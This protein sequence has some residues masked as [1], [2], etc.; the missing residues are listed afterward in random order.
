MKTTRVVIVTGLSGSGKTTTINALEDLGFFCVDN[1]P[2][3]LMD[4]FLS[5][6]E[7]DLDIRKVALGIDARDRRNLDRF[8]DTVISLRQRGFDIDVVFLDCSSDDILIRRYSETR[9]RHPLELDAGSLGAAITLERKLLAP[10]K[11]FSTWL[12]DSSELNVHQLKRLIVQSY[13]HEDGHKMGVNLI[14]FGFKHGSPREAD[15]QIDCRL[16]PN[17]YFVEELRAKTGLDP[18]IQT[19]LESKPEWDGFL[20]RLL[21]LLRFAVPLHVVEGKPTLVIAIGCTG[22]QHRSVAVCEKLAAQ[23][24]E[25]GF[26]VSVT[27]RE[28]AV[29]PE[30]S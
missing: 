26:T 25:D 24:R 13:G 12:I 14:S 15:W 2:I 19:W 4:T 20:D 28:L 22:G 6:T 5:L 23:L 29:I 17:P 10:I 3:V 8:Q 27:H 7:S 11:D 18:E 1:I 16:L 30:E 9:R 21:G